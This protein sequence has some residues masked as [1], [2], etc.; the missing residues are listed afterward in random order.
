[1]ATIS[2]AIDMGMGKPLERAMTTSIVA[3]RLGEA[4]GLS[5]EE[6]CDT[7]Y[8]AFLRYIG[9]NADTYWAASV[10]GDGLA[11]STDL[12]KI[13]NAGNLRIL[14]VLLRHVRQANATANQRKKF[15]SFEQMFRA[16]A[17]GSRIAAAEVN[18]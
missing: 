12:A 18:L 9:R 3:V 14:R 7:Y 15:S 1:M 11:V 8:G 4:A 10:Y 13:D 5:E 16:A 6:W 2:I 17:T